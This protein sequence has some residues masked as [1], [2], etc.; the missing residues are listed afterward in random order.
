MSD[1]QPVNRERYDQMLEWF[2][3][4]AN[5][6]ELKTAVLHFLF[7]LSYPRPDLLMAEKIVRR[8]NGWPG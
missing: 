4:T 2:R 1:Y 8:E 7:D 3:E 6:A 5:N